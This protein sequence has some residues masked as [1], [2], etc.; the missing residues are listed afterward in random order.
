MFLSHSTKLFCKVGWKLCRVAI[1]W[2][3]IQIIQSR[4]ITQ[5]TLWNS[6]TD[7]NFAAVMVEEKSLC[8]HYSGD[9]ALQ[10]FLVLIPPLHSVHR[11][12]YS[13]HQKSEVMHFVDELGNLLV[14]AVE[15][16]QQTLSDYASPIWQHP[17]FVTRRFAPLQKDESIKDSKV[18]TSTPSL[19]LSW[20]EGKS[21]SLAG[22]HDDLTKSVEHLRA[23]WSSL[24]T[25]SSCVCLGVWDQK[26]F[27]FH[28]GGVWVTW[29]CWHTGWNH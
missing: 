7:C 24:E 15:V 23:Q 3:W 9:V 17:S 8:F 4:M 13:V 11:R 29:C 19:L 22:L 12:V 21:L 16:W 2:V 27:V 14:S 1:E 10:E 25:R 28:I 20:D 26:W 5:L 6:S 18:F